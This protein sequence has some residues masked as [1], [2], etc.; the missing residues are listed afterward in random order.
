VATLADRSAVRWKWSEIKRQKGVPGE[1]RAFT[2][3]ADPDGDG[4]LLRVDDT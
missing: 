3:T 2:Y 4:W 1:R